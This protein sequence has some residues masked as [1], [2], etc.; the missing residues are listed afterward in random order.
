MISSQHV[1]WPSFYMFAVLHIWHEKL[2]TGLFVAHWTAAIFFLLFSK[3]QICVALCKTKSFCQW[4]LVLFELW[5]SAAPPD[6]PCSSWLLYKLMPSCPVRLGRN[7]SANLPHIFQIIGVQNNQFMLFPMKFLIA[8]E[9]IWKHFKWYEK[10]YILDCETSTI[11][12]LFSLFS[13]NLWNI[14]QI[15]SY[16]C[17]N[18]LNRSAL[19]RRRSC[20]KTLAKQPLSSSSF[21]KPLR[22]SWPKRER[23]WEHYRNTWR[24]KCVSYCYNT[25]I[26]FK[27]FHILSLFHIYLFF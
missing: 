2:Q 12:W 24:S 3:V 4:N 1:W 13:S 10:M 21:L 9:K 26:G 27:S 20:P 19:R 15:H 14:L 7:P 11:M 17:Y 8:Y 16:V 23:L 5:I 25:R 18:Y 6:L 22:S